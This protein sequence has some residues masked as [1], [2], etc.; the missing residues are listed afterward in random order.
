[1]SSKRP[2]RSC[3]KRK[4]P[5]HSYLCGLLSESQDWLEGMEGEEVANLSS[6]I[7]TFLAKY[8]AVQESQESSEGETIPDEDEWSANEDSEHSSDRDFIVNDME[9]DMEDEEYHPDDSSSEEEEWNG[10]DTE[11]TE[12]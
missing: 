5:S 7:N 3:R 9:D 10:S 12:E 11:E 8:Q 6:S 1:M 2:R 4:A